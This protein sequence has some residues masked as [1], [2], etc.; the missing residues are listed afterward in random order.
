MALYKKVDSIN[1]AALIL[2]S[3]FEELWKIVCEG[4]NVHNWRGKC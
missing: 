3:S 4:G 2:F 1:S